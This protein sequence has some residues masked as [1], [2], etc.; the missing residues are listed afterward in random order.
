M[1]GDDLPG[2]SFGDLMDRQFH[3]RAPLV[4]SWLLERSLN[5]IH[6]PAGAGKSMVCLGLS[7]GLAG[8]RDFLQW[9]IQQARKVLYLDAEMEPCDLQERGQELIDAAGM[10]KEQKRELRSNLRVF[11]QQDPDVVSKVPD[12]KEE[13]KEAK[14]WLSEAVRDFK[15]DLVV[16]DNLST[17]ADV[18]DENSAGGFSFV[19]EI[20]Q[21]LKSLGCAVL[22]VHHDRKGQSSSES[23]RG[24]GKLEA[25]LDTRWGMR[26]ALGGEGFGFTIEPYK[27]RHRK[28]DDVYPFT[29]RLHTDGAGAFWSHS[30]A[31]RT[32]DVLENYVNAVTSCNYAKAKEVAEALRVSESTVSR[33]AK[34]AITQKLISKEEIKECFRKAKEEGDF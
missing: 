15:A 20:G 16:I 17:F 11:N 1:R 6:A 8:G 9:P 22:F 33:L 3:P 32:E 30:D 24:S 10:S 25:P 31:S 14:E 21:F 12:L 29:A 2:L 13:A 26:K 18:D 7:M 19:V 34:Q 5:M 4:G 28:G 23:F 27:V